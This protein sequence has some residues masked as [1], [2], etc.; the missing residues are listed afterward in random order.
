MNETLAY[1]R[2]RRL[3]LVRDFVVW[4]SL[5]AYEFSFLITVLDQST[6]RISF[7]TVPLGGDL[8]K[9]AFADLIDFRGNNLPQNLINPKVIALPKTSTGVVVVAQEESESFTIAKTS[10]VDSHGLCDLIVMEVG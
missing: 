10:A 8:Q 7:L 5:S 2:G 6:K 3:W 4:G 9:V 1:L